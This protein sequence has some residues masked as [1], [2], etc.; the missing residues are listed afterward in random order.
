M[1]RV[2]LSSQIDAMHFTE[3]PLDQLNAVCCSLERGDVASQAQP[4]VSSECAVKLQ[5]RNTSFGCIPRPVTVENYF[6][7]I[8]PRRKSTTV[9]RPLEFPVFGGPNCSA[10]LGVREP[11]LSNPEFGIWSFQILGAPSVQQVW[12]FRVS[13]IEILVAPTVQLVLD[14]GNRDFRLQ[15]LAQALFEGA[16]EFRK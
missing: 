5:N 14:F 2:V 10:G 16:S 3:D 11:R 12:A 8:Y 7:Y 15:N 9:W 4:A 13:S 1:S 6:P